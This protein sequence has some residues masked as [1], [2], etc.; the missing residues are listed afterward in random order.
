MRRYILITALMALTAISL[1]SC[2]KGED[3]P[4]ALE[5]DAPMELRVMTFNIEWG[6]AHISFNNVVEA[7]RLAKA[8]IVGIQ[9]AEGNLKR[10]A[11]ALGWHYDLRNYVI[12]R[13]PLIDPPGADGMYVYVEVEPGRI[14]A[15][16]NV[17]LPSDPYGPDALRDGASTEEVLDIERAVRLPKIK[18]Y[19]EILRPL[20]AR[21]IPVFMTGDFNAPAH[22]DWVEAMIG[23]RPFLTRAIDWPVSRAVTA[24][25]FKDSWRVIYPDPVKDP[26]LTWWAG[27]PP[28]ELY[29]PGE[30]DVQ[31]RIDFLWFDGPATIQ[32]SEIVGE[33]N[34]ADVTISVMPW[35]SDHRAVVSQFKVMSAPMPPLIS[36]AHRVYRTGENVEV[37]T[38]TSAN[39]PISVTVT[40]AEDAQH[41][42][43]EQ[44]VNG[45]GHLA[46]PSALFT[47]GEYKIEMGSAG[48]SAP[49][50]RNFWV[51]EAQAR[52]TVEVIGLAFDQNDPIEI[53]WHNSPGNRN[54]YVKV[55]K[56]GDP[57][58]NEGD[59]AWAYTKARPDGRLYLD[60]TTSENGWP[61]EPGSY[62]IRLMKD[63]GNDQ[64]AV[65]QRFIVR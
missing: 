50:S 49:L 3:D 34:R 30:N 23:E 9:E 13:Y 65:S 21:D 31:D 5:P 1:L 10:L 26:G 45:T 38:H 29:S 44:L 58:V 55:Y 22:T 17:H 14:V 24:A 37:Y 52:P 36:T 61:L 60:R 51:L 43:A 20:V 53:R 48:N 59:G 39:T 41:V 32:S 15:I 40:R 6:G 42:I 7:I 33:A 25:G 47:P 62:N 27:R 12:S 2:S 46:F 35:P 63:D 16:A 57:T 56:L 54:D 19:L 11:A 18:P 8:D 4:A 28:L 64:L